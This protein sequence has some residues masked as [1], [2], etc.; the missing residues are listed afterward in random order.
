MTKVITVFVYDAG[1][2]SFDIKERH[3]GVGVARSI[4]HITDM[5]YIPMSRYA[6]GP[7]YNVGARG[8]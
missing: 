4:Q 2:I 8:T 1:P 7:R 3:Q 6:T 5:H